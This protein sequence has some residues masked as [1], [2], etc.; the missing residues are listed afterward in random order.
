MGLQLNKARLKTRILCSLSD[1]GTS[2][3]KFFCAKV[4]GST[5]EFM[6]PSR[7]TSVTASVD[8]N[9]TSNTELGHASPSRNMFVMESKIRVWN[10]ASQLNTFK[11][12]NVY[13]KYNI[14]L[15]QPISTAKSHVITH[16]CFFPI[17]SGARS[18]T[19]RE[20]TLK[21]NYHRS[22]AYK[23]PAIK[24]VNALVLGLS[25]NGHKPRYAAIPNSQY[26]LKCSCR[27]QFASLQ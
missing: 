25:A 23:N 27:S 16:G 9:S 26:I 19:M 7:S 20:I 5:H 13:P 17:Y 6:R 22:V 8:A 18:A 12:N 2:N 14:V 15:F 24:C 11:I 21:P 10:K 4:F 1:E 3:R